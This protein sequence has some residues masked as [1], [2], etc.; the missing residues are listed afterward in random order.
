MSDEVLAH[1][2]SALK[3]NA[4]QCRRTSHCSSALADPLCVYMQVWSPLQG[5]DLPTLRHNVFADLCTL[6]L[7]L[8]DSAMCSSLAQP[9]VSSCVQDVDFSRKATKVTFDDDD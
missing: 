9:G 3:I 6:C 4:I 5:M 2:T 8:L 1:C 7:P